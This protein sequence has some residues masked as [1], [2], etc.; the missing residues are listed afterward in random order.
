MDE[1]T[2][3]ELQKIFKQW[4]IDDPRNAPL[5]DRRSSKLKLYNI[6]KTSGV[7]PN[8][9]LHDLPLP[10]ELID[11]IISLGGDD[12]HTLFSL[13]S[14]YWYNIIQKTFE[15]RYIHLGR[16]ISP[17]NRFSYKLLYYRDRPIYGDKLVTINMINN[18]HTTLSIPLSSNIVSYAGL[19]LL[20]LAD[21]TYD[22]C[23]LNYMY[24]KHIYDYTH[25]FLYVDNR[26]ELWIRIHH[27]YRI[28]IMM[29]S[30]ILKLLAVNVG[31]ETLST[32][33]TDNGK[34]YIQYGQQ[35]PT[36]IPGHLMCNIITKNDE[37]YGLSYNNTVYK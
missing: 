26:R 23:G 10:L 35:Y 20:Q 3:R 27:N 25:T 34:V 8:K 6:L 17:I 14:W 5:I 31:V 1:F 22:E 13:T 24:K 30:A 19:P 15:K 37:I 28:R 2:Y 36:S 11:Y 4:R 32:I 7:L 18:E 16:Y 33:L 12:V 9:N 21:G 29:D